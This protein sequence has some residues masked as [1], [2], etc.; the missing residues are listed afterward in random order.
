[1]LGPFGG[2][3]LDPTTFLATTELNYTEAFRRSHDQRESA[4]TPDGQRRKSGINML[5]GLNNET[6]AGKEDP[7][8]NKKKPSTEKPVSLSKYPD[9]I[10]Y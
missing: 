2:A 5:P 1:M 6:A 7:N 9:I 4:T 3:D 8:G 10:N